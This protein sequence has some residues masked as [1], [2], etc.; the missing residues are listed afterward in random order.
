ME[1][2][3]TAKK[4]RLGKEMHFAQ[5]MFPEFFSTAAMKGLRTC[6]SETSLVCKNNVTGQKK[7]FKLSDAIETW[8]IKEYG[9]LTS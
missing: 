2:L 9:L 8:Y 7:A 4:E 1:F 3:V 6:F 5:A